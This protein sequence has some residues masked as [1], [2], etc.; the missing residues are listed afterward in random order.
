MKGFTPDLQTDTQSTNIQ[1]LI[2]KF[3]DNVSASEIL[4]GALV[5]DVK[6]KTGQKNLVGHPL[7]RPI[8][9]YIPVRTTAPL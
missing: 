4:D 2:K 7:N 3:A 9:G 5:E 8:K 1:Q 6:L